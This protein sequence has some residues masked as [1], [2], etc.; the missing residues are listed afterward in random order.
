M[1]PIKEY[2]KYELI[3]IW[4]PK[5]CIHA[6]FCAKTFLLKH[7]P[8]EKPWIKPEGALITG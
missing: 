8:K 7:Y 3:I 6:G 5:K 2:T 1:Q 4:K